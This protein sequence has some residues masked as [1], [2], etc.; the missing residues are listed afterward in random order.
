MPS[1]DDA[2][3]VRVK[4]AGVN[5][6]DYKAIGG[7]AATSIYPHILGIDFAGVLERVPRTERDLHAGDRVFG[8]ARTHGSWAEYTKVEAGAVAEPVVPIPEGVSDDQAAALPASAA[9]A[10]G[11]LELLGVSAGQRVLVLGG[12]GAV[13]GYAVQMAHARGAHVIAT[14]RGDPDD[15]FRLG[16]DEVYDSK[17]LDPV[18][19]LRAAHPDGIDAILDPISDAGAIRHEADILRAGGNIVSTV[20]AADE[21]WFAER[22]IHARNLTAVTNPFNSAKGLS[23]LARMLA[24]GVITARVSASVDLNAAGDLLER[25]RTGGLHGKAVIRM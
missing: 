15:A 5:P 21:R 23:E 24:G 11:S 17:S 2:F 12:A 3:L 4:F 16:A 22:H 10:R 20:G 8:E 7:L 6:I 9:A 1:A 19:A 25:I 14:V 13:G 18:E